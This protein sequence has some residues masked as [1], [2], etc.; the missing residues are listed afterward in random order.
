MVR[1][2]MGKLYVPH[3]A[4]DVVE[5]SF[6]PDMALAWGFGARDL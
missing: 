1:D 6:R 4:C 2:E 5:L 3:T